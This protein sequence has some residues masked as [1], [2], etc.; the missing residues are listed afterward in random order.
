MLNHATDA[1]GTDIR[2]DYIYAAYIERTTP[3]SPP[4]D[5]RIHA[6]SASRRNCFASNSTTSD[7]ST[8]CSGVGAC[9]EGTCQCAAGYSGLYCQTGSGSGGSSSDVTLA[10]AIAL[11]IGLGFLSLLCLG[12]LL[13]C[14][15]RRRWQQREGEDGWMIDSGELKMI[16]PLGEG[17]FGQV[18]K[19][20][21]REEEV[22]VK[23]LTSEVCDSKAAR[24]A[25]LNE[26]KI[27]SQLRHPNVVL[28]MAASVTPHMCIVM[29]FMSLGSLFD[30]PLPLSLYR[31]DTYLSSKLSFTI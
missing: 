11:P 24:Q 5:L 6:T 25:F 22:A 31:Q 29:E 7:P 15:L 3:M 10:L 2:V 17:S 28:F 21:W 18:W 23:T 19:A 14:L 9:R 13:L 26:M 30:V 27:M 20:K 4:R 16:Q 12:L 1:V 8:M